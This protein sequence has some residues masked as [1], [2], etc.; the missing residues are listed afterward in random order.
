[1]SITSAAICAA[2][3]R[4]QGFVG[5]NRKTAQHILRFSED[6]F[7]LDVAQQSIIPCCEFVWQAFD[8]NLMRLDRSRLQLLLAQNIDERLNISEPLR[9]YMRR[10]DRPEITAQRSLLKSK[11]L[12][13]SL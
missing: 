10:Q 8:G 5:Y 7:G 4:L 3:D 9:L 12:A 1:M 13:G 11:A 2:A 6:A